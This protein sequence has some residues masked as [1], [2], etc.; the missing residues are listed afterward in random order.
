MRIFAILIGLASVAATVCMA[1][2]TQPTQST[3]QNNSPKA[4][5]QSLAISISTGDASAMRNL[6]YAKS[7]TDQKLVSA[8]SDTAVAVAELRRALVTKFGSAKANT[9]LPDPAEVIRSAEQNMKSAVEK[10]DGDTATVSTGQPPRINTMTMKKIDGQWKVDVT[11]YVRVGS[12]E[13][14]EKM[15]TSVNRSVAVFK[16]L[17]SD[18]NS[19]K[20][21]TAEAVNAEMKQR[22]ASVS[23]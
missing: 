7:D 8:I 9:V 11:A 16:G 14:L 4:A 3:T 10:I 23:R 21:D 1:Q 22:M 18:V 12:G 2:S 19:G 13:Q 20:L 5:V 17:L 15:L 6:L